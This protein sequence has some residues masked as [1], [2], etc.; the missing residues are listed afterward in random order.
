MHLIAI[1]AVLA[2]KLISYLRGAKMADWN[3]SQYLKFK[4]QRTQ[5]A[6]D[7]AMRMINRKPKKIADIGCGPGN[8]RSMQYVRIAKRG[9]R[10]KASAEVFRR[11]LL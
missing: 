8:S 3:S 2:I 1:V 7:L 4:N 6:V 11:I 9:Q 5:P 10:W